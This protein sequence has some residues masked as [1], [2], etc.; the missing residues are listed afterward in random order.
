MAILIIF[1]LITLGVAI[2]LLRDFR[3]KRRL[4]SLFA[5]IQL[6]ISI[7]AIIFEI[8][9]AIATQGWGIGAF[10]IIWENPIFRIL[11]PITFIEPLFQETFSIASFFIVFSHFGALQWYLYGYLIDRFRKRKIRLN[12]Y[13]TIGA[14]L[15][16]AILTI[17]SLIDVVK[18][19]KPELLFSNQVFNSVNLYETGSNRVISDI[20]KVNNNW[21]LTDKIMIYQLD[22]QFTEISRFPIDIQVSN[23]S[24]TMRFISNAKIKFCDFYNDGKPEFIAYDYGDPF[25]DAKYTDLQHGISFYDQIGKRQW[26]K[27]LNIENISLKPESDS[28]KASFLAVNNTYPDNSL[29]E[30]N[31]NGEILKNDSISG[32]ERYK[33]E[34]EVESFNE[35]KYEWE[36]FT[37]FY[38]EDVVRDYHKIEI[39]DKNENVIHKQHPSEVGCI[40]VSDNGYLIGEE[41]KLIRFEKKKN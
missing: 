16:F 28:T 38:V 29:I 15:Y 12:K 21:Y 2:L 33:M 25:F 34:Y 9:I 7:I 23:V 24:D 30:F 14:A 40:Y 31:L 20:I 19:H 6:L 18:I 3:Q 10:I 1:I 5:A 26:F 11:Y 39:L 35:K 36:D 4:S 32:N 37:L 41:G 17:I 27:K 13:K 22:S 8:I